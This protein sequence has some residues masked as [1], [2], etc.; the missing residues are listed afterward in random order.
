VP[1]HRLQ[2]EREAGG[3]GKEL[4]RRLLGLA[5]LTAVFAAASLLAIDAAQ[6]SAATKAVLVKDI[7][8][9]DGSDPDQL[10]SVDGTLFFAHTTGPTV[11]PFARRESCRA[12]ILS[13]RLIERSYFGAIL[14]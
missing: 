1:K 9:S 12:R 10:T 11:P 8:R 14:S 4:L 2:H 13:Q 5:L 6:A 7:G 3:V